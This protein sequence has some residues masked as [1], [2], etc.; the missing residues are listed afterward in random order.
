[1]YLKINS[2]GGSWGLVCKMKLHG[3]HAGSVI[4]YSEYM[5]IKKKRVNEQKAGKRSN[6]G[7]SLKKKHLLPN[8]SNNNNNRSPQELARQHVRTLKINEEGW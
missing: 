8:T 4:F 5:A 3:L 6:R 7:I 1:M 2:G